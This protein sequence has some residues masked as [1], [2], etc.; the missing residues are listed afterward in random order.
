MVAIASHAFPAYIALL[1]SYN[2]YRDRE[3]RKF[4]DYFNS[5]AQLHH[6]SE[7]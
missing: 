7:L 1:N 3:I 2:L 4:E 5:Q 6:S